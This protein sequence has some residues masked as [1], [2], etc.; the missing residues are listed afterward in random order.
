MRRAVT[1]PIQDIKKFS[2]YILIAYA[3]SPKVVRAAFEV[4]CRLEP[5][6]KSLTVDGVAEF[7]GPSVSE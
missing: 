2:V 7:G 5:L 6:D 1:P 3:E 4:V